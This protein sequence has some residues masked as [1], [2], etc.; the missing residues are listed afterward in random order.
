M[1]TRSS[2]Q[3]GA[4][5]ERLVVCSQFEGTHW[6]LP[7]QGPGERLLIGWRVAPPSPN[8]EVPRAVADLL[9]M[10]LCQSAT[11]TFATA[12]KTPFG[13]SFLSRN[14]R[15]NRHFKWTSTSDSKVAAAGIFLG[16]PF[17]WNLQAQVVILS[18]PRTSPRLD[19]RHLA[20][21][22]EP[23][24]FAE[25]GRLGAT[26]ALLPGVD[27]DVAGLYTSA[28]QDMRAFENDFSML[29]RKDGD[30]LVS[31]SEEVFGQLLGTAEG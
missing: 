1:T 31:V 16:E 25:L 7:V 12:I 23:Q 17:A 26:G 24:L 11:L 30:E 15:L 3:A 22:S 13:A 14:W 9:M 27:G 19:E 2:S 20:L 10:A 6:Q 18:P 4:R 29:A 21:L 5:I 8:G 28:P